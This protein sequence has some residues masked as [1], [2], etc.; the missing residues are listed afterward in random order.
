MSVEEALAILK[1]EVVEVTRDGNRTLKV[2]C[3]NSH[4]ANGLIGTYGV[5]FGHNNVDDV[6]FHFLNTDKYAYP[7]F[8]DAGTRE[9]AYQMTK[10][11]ME[12]KQVTINT[13]T[14]TSGGF[15][16][17]TDTQTTTVAADEDPEKE[18]DWTTY[19][20]LG[21]AAAVIILILWDKK[22]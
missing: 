9:E 11:L 15:G 14:V 3:S 20:I 7:R 21:A 13:G 6:G 16:Y 12:G 19:I 1:N 4:Y 10:D 5:I 17:T 18:T 2:K 22:K 8:R